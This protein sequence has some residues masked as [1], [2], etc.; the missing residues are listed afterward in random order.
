MKKRLPVEGKR[1]VSQRGKGDLQYL[2]IKG[3]IAD[4]PKAGMNGSKFFSTAKVLDS[5]RKG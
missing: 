5:E 3:L 2:F 1:E 4:K